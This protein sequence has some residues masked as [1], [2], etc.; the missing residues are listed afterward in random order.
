MMVPL[1]AMTLVRST[2]PLVVVAAL[3]CCALTSHAQPSALDAKPFPDEQA[4]ASFTRFIEARMA[5]EPSAGL[6]VA[7]WLDGRVWAK[8][9]GYRD[10]ERELPAT[11]DTSYRMASVTKPFTA[12]AALQLYEQGK[13]DLD[14]D[15]R[16]YVP[17]FP[18][19]KHV[20]TTRQLLGHLSGIPH[21]KNCARECF[22][23]THH[24]TRQAI[25]IFDGFPLEHA[26]GERY[27][28]SSYG[29]N[30]IGAA[31]EGASGLSYGEVL[32]RDVFGRAGMT[33]SRMDDPKADIEE[34]AR[35][36]RV[37]NGELRPSDFVDISS[38]FAG[39]G[40]R[41]TVKDMVAFAAAY[42]NGK[43]LRPA[44][45]ELL[46]RSMVTNDGVLTDYG[47]GFA[48]VPQSGRFVLAHGGGQPETSTLLVLYPAERF[49]V[50][51][52]ANVEGY[53]QVLH[54]VKELIVANVL[55]DGG[56]RRTP[57]GD[58]E[59]S[60]VVAR[61]VSGLMSHGVAHFTRWR[62]GAT[63]SPGELGRAFEHLHEIL[64]R[65]RIA[66]D[67]VAALEAARLGDDPVAGRAYLLAGAH[68]AGVIAD[69][70]GLP[71]LRRYHDDE[72][73]AFVLD[74]AAVCAARAC[75]RPYRLSASL[76]ERVRALQQDWQKT[77]VAAVR[78]LRVYPGAAL[79]ALTAALSAFEGARVHPDL[80]HELLQA[81]GALEA[82]GDD[83][84]ARAFV[85]LALA[86]HPLSARA[87]LAGVERA[88][89]EGDG[90]AARSLLARWA[91]VEDDPIAERGG[92]LALRAK[93]LRKKQLAAALELLTLGN[94]LVPKS[95]ELLDEL[96]SI[97]AALGQNARAVDALQAAQSIA[98]EKRRARRLQRLRDKLPKHDATLQ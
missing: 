61:A 97:A 95:P 34:R 62:R 46:E 54:E 15:V 68:M 12:I 88:L 72:P 80:S 24:T 73:F 47:M 36:Y 53:H 22:L 57:I 91:R 10:R 41:S 17:Y 29:Y 39:G 43:L 11:A 21:Y 8:G 89:L 86:R 2:R 79:T 28:Y 96:A 1:C 55:G 67:P 56:A 59:A 93:R 38:R 98:P 71:A 58:D 90:G 60:N 70:R 77:N 83:E 20:V 51:V 85:Q 81:A 78:A 32:R 66:A 94:E 49:A 14:A 92:A 35:G 6:S 74:Y 65:D 30:L 25:A 45:Q 3:L 31:V 4:L 19:K 50:A 76:V 69:Q 84:K 13:L 63:G 75:P 44:T 52:A 26:P 7:F 42:M 16:R 87:L 33:R 9:F 48:V 37:V 82:R 23:K 5:E 64:D 40:T 18:K 27:L